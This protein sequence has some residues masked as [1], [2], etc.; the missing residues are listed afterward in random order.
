MIAQRARSSQRRKRSSDKARAPG[1]CSL[2]RVCAMFRRTP[3]RRQKRRGESA[4]D[5]AHLRSGLARVAIASE[6]RVRVGSRALRT[7]YVTRLVRLPP[8]APMSVL[9]FPSIKRQFVDADVAHAAKTVTCSDVLKYGHLP[10]LTPRNLWAI[11]SIAPPTPRSR[12]DRQ[13][14]GALQPAFQVFAGYGSRINGCGIL[15]CVGGDGTARA[16]SLSSLTLARRR[17]EA[18]ARSN[19]CCN[20]GAVSR[21]YQ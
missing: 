16:R 11:E 8:L 12:E 3:A 21:L 5:W 14:S 18:E 6:V 9:R 10:E 15:L 1:H 4:H 20:E 13:L 2:R 19:G 17:D 7:R